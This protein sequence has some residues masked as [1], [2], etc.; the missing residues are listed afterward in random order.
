L[1]AF[2][3]IATSWTIIDDKAEVDRVA[4]ICQQKAGNDDQPDSTGDSPSENPPESSFP[5][6][7]I[8]EQT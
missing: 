4:A 3:F 6:V 8:G 7:T 2:A 5:V 1:G